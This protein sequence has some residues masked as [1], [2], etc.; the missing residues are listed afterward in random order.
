MSALHNP[1]S[2][3]LNGFTLVEL[4]MVL[5]I[6]A[7]LATAALNMVEFQV[8]QTRFETTQQT[9]DSVRDAILSE[10]KTDSGRLLSGFFVD[11]GRLPRS[12]QESLTT[13]SARELWDNSPTTTNLPSF[14]SVAA[15]NT[16]TVDN[17]L[18]T[19]D[20]DTDTVSGDSR[21]TLGMGW[22]GPYLRMPVGAAELTDGWGTSLVSD[23]G[24]SHLRTL[25]VGDADMDANFDEELDVTA[26][27]VSIFGVR[28]LGRD[29]VLGGADYNADLP[30]IIQNP[31]TSDLEN[32]LGLKSSQLSGTVTG[33]VYVDQDI[34]MIAATALQNTVVQLYYPDSTV[35]GQFAVQVADSAV[36]AAPAV[37]ELTLNATPHPT[38]HVFDFRFD[39]GNGGAFEFPI[40]TRV[41]RAYYND[42]ENSDSTEDFGDGTDDPAH[43]SR[44]IKFQL[45]PTNSQ[46]ELTIND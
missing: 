46:L 3:N 2:L 17:V 33:R 27:G 40:G 30:A 38:H 23:A 7:I 34:E 20:A 4:I 37:V 9:V 13:F 15:A 29:T 11:M 16:A 28:S 14:A 6:L 42:S 18:N 31:V 32:Q 45:F 10:R 25:D 36:P 12:Y 35:V 5:V 22:Q 44:E 19:A 43:A 8:D 24:Y 39:D 1:R 26:A 21:V 41:I